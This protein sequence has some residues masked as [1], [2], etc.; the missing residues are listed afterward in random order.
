MDNSE[1]IFEPQKRLFDEIQK[2]LPAQFALVD[3]ISEVLDISLD[4]AYRRIRCETLLSIKET[5]TL[6][7]HFRIS[8]D[9]LMDVKNINQFDCIY[10]PINLSVPNEYESYMFALSKNIEK[11]RSSSDSSIIMS[12]MDIPV[13]H[14]ISKKE[15]TFFKLYTWYHSVYNYKGCMDDF[16]KEIDTPEIIGCYQKIIRD[17]EFIPSAEIWTENTVNTTLRLISYYLEICMFLKKDLPIL[18]CEQ[19]LDILDKLQKWAENS[20]KGEQKASFQLYVSEM[21][22]E[23]TYILMKQSGLT[24][25][26]VK[27]FTINS[28]NVLDKGFCME[29]ENWLNKLAQR[30]DLLCGNSE[31]ERIKFFNTQ[32]Q[33]V[34]FLMKKIQNSF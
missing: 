29:T 6:S 13:F 27:S 11:L 14:L 8:L 4:S 21:E 23:N 28:L 10:R 12:A 9:M 30:S 7:K 32:R 15:L 19:I 25:C 33:N 34:R 5:Y 26:V 31:K 22:P 17:Y 16:L 3:T 24:N 2:N 20:Y 18:L 1:K